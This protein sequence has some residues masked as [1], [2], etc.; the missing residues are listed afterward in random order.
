MLTNQPP[1]GALTFGH[2][3]FAG[4]VI[5]CIVLALVLIAELVRLAECILNRRKGGKS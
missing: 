4:L 2:G 3:I 5:L 1:P